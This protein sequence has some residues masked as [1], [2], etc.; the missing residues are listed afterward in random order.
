MQDIDDWI[1]KVASNLG[2]GTEEK[3]TGL[4]IPNLS[5]GVHPVL[6]HAS[7]CLSV[8]IS[9]EKGRHILVCIQ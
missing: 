3:D 4:E 7:Q 9:E 1:R 8:K 6:T 2:Q 5:R